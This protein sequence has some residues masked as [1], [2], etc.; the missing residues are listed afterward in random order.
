MRSIISLLFLSF[1][2]F[3]QAQQFSD[4]EVVYEKEGDVINKVDFYD[5]MYGVAVGDDGLVLLTEDGGE[6]WVDYSDASMGDLIHVDLITKDLFL[7]NSTTEVFKTTNAGKDWKKTFS[8]NSVFINSVSM[9]PY[10]LNA[11]MAF[12]NC[13]AGIVYSSNSEGDKWYLQDV[14]ALISKTDRVLHCFGG[15]YDGFPDSIFQFVT[16]EIGWGQTADDFKTLDDNSEILKTGGKI[17]EVVNQMDFSEGWYA[18]DRIYI[19]DNNEVRSG[20]TGDL[21]SGGTD[22]INCCVWSRRIASDETN[23][24]GWAVGPNGYISESFGGTTGNFKQISSPTTKDLNWI[25]WAGNYLGAQQSTF[26]KATFCI[27]GD[28]VILQKRVNWEP[29]PVGLPRIANDLHTDVYP[30]PFES[31]FTVETAGWDQNESIQVRLYDINGVL[32]KDL[33]NGVLP[34]RNLQ[35][36]VEGGL[37]QGVYLLE[38]SSA[39]KRAVHRTVKQ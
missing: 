23:W 29:D 36:Q 5:H 20:R 9:T 8:N 31:Y 28:G 27:V 14:G 6:N 21:M 12:I 7:T 17:K 3:S 10:I 26:L 2:S 35:L 13:D 24:Y 38:I 39:S 22:V 34:D 4:W 25:A 1:F 33:Y 11:N 16:T 18:Q 15:S 30:N 32:I 19:G 37:P